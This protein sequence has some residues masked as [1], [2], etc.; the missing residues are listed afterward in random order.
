MKN[1][2]SKVY[3]EFMHAIKLII[4]IFIT[5]SLLIAYLGI[6]V[7]IGII[8]VFCGIFY[9]FSDQKELPIYYRKF[10]KRN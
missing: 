2:N 4:S 9:L 3:G 10:N 7:T 6:I 8:T 5:I 1:K